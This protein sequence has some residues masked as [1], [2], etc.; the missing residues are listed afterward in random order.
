[1]RTRASNERLTD[2]FAR[3]R[4]WRAPLRKFLGTRWSLNDS[5][6]DDV[7][8]EVFL[9]LL[10]YDNS[11]LIEHPQAY[12]FRMASNVAGEWALRSR[13]RHPHDAQWLVELC[14]TSDP[15]GEVARQAA[16]E[17]VRRAI[18]SLPPRQREV[19]RLH[20]A[21]GLARWQIAERL[22]ASE[23]VV[24]RELINAYSSLRTVLNSE[25]ADD[26]DIH[27]RKE[28]GPE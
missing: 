4:R 23:R 12:L 21:E 6:F 13:H 27:T 16:N 26:L 3:F 15:E 7:A 5:D 10:R 2:W 8:Q 11:E 19:V 9:R 17:Q 24:K 18:E 14:A 28:Y 20:F 25:I 22:N 1:M